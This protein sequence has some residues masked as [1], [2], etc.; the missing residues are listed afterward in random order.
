MN[1]RDH[2]H[3]D[4]AILGGKPVFKGTRITVELLLKLLAA[5]W[6]ETKIG[7]E[8]PGIGRDQIRAAAAF[9]ADFLGDETYV[10]IAQAK[11]A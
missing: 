8:Y 7:G 6:D 5:G 4:P 3:S 11:A 2:I 10:A 1:W 9:A